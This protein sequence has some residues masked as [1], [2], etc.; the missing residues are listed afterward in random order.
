MLYK[1]QTIF[2]SDIPRIIWHANIYTKSQAIKVQ[3][4]DNDGQQNRLTKLNS[5]VPFQYIFCRVEMGGRFA[6]CLKEGYTFF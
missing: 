3:K 1:S 4:D 2:H 5:I 6:H